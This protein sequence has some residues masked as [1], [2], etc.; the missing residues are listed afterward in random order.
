MLAQLR[1]L[2]FL[3]FK[4]IQIINGI[5]I[6]DVIELIGRLSSKPGNCEIISA[7]NKMF[8]P[9]KMENGINI[10]WSVVLHIILAK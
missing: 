5:P 8:I 1:F 6:K 9:S 10:L 4:I 3:F 7:I 2:I